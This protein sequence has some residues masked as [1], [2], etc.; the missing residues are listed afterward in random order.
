MACPLMKRKQTSIK[1]DSDI[2]SGRFSSKKCKVER[3]MNGEHVHKV[4]TT[5]KGHR[6]LLCV[7]MLQQV[8]QRNMQLL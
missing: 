5:L 1:K 4:R 8:I 7:E 2:A 6:P 3:L